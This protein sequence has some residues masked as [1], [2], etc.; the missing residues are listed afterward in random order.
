MDEAA[1]Q[2][3]LYAFFPFI[4]TYADETVLNEKDKINYHAFN[5]ALFEFPAYEYFV[6]GE[7][8]GDCGKMNL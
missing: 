1:R 4:A 7:K 5:P 6:T 3:F 2:Q 8:I